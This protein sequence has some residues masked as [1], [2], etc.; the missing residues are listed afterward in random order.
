VENKI[1]S[2]K[3][4]ADF[5]ITLSEDEMSALGR[6]LFDYI[7]IDSK[8]EPLTTLDEFYKYQLGEVLLTES[9]PITLLVDPRKIKLL[10]SLLEE[11]SRFQSEE[12]N[13]VRRELLD[14]LILLDASLDHLASQEY[15]DEEFNEII[16]TLNEPE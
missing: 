4:P 10:M 16:E 9:G 8:H 5:K 11:D 13:Q 1:N 15:F 2:S 7:F 12:M 3:E 14:D 6:A